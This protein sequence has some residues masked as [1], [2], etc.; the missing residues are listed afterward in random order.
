MKVDSLTLN[1]RL[2]RFCQQVQWCSCRLQRPAGLPSK[3]CLTLP[4]PCLQ[5]GRFHDLTMF[6]GDNRSCRATL[7]R[8]AQRRLGTRRRSGG[9]AAGTGSGDG[10]N[11]AGERASLV[12]RFSAG[13]FPTSHG[14]FDVCGAAMSADA[15]VPATGSLEAVAARAA[16]SSAGN[17]VRAFCAACM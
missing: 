7:L 12:S 13:A 11:A 1:G 2:V 4:P 15:P 16:H 8:H 3:H 17:T 10:D 9:Q 14:I 6:E 5:C